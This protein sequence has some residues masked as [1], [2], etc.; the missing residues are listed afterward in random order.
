MSKTTKSSKITAALTTWKRSILIKW[1]RE[2]N[3]SSMSGPLISNFTRR[4]SRTS[5]GFCVWIHTWLQSLTY[6]GSIFRKRTVSAWSIKTSLS[7]SSWSLRCLI[8]SFLLG[9][10]FSWIWTTYWFWVVLMTLMRM[11]VISLRIMSINFRYWSLTKMRRCTYAMLRVRWNRDEVVSGFAQM[12]I[13]CMSLAVLWV[14]TSIVQKEQC[15]IS[16]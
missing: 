10:M 16:I 14:E 3:K 12:M 15:K 11:S 5:W 8:S 13:L 1:S 9:D 2:S 7:G 6:A 4:S